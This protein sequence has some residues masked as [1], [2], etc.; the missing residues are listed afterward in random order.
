MVL[1]KTN[2]LSI[3]YLHLTSNVAFFFQDTCV[4]GKRRTVKE[5]SQRK[6][7]RVKIMPNFRN[8]ITMKPMKVKF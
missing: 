1:A 6:V 3:Q 4:H 5:W 7:G 8:E 2:S